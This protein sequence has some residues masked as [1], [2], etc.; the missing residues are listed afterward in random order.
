MCR[1]VELEGVVRRD[2][3]EKEMLQSQMRE[4]QVEEREEAEAEER[5]ALQN[6]IREL[7]L[8]LARMGS[9]NEAESEAVMVALKAE[10]EALKKK[11][12]KTQRTVTLS[13]AANQGDDEA[14]QDLMATLSAQNET[15]S[16]ALE[17]LRS[18]IA[19]DRLETLE[20]EN[21]RLRAE[22]QSHPA[23]G[24]QEVSE[25]DARIT[26]LQAEVSRLTEDKA[27]LHSMHE[28]LVQCNAALQAELSRLREEGFLREAEMEARSREGLELRMQLSEALDSVERVNAAYK[29]MEGAFEGAKSR[30]ME[31]EG[32]VCVLEEAGRD[33]KR[34]ARRV[35]ECEREM[36][37][38]RESMNGLKIRVEVLGR[39]NEGLRSQLEDLKG[40]AEV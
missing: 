19:S 22:L 39:E 20:L 31:L 17:A 27:Q 21:A 28:E 35:E 37:G 6:R 11:V 40:V 32:T 2:G 25:L 8:E 36:K 26:V 16:A 33:A 34:Q 29:E 23:F 24:K 12:A 18:P 38:V 14:S 7:E 9:V 5:E 15:L 3:E 30:V 10:N 1:I 4:V 13:N